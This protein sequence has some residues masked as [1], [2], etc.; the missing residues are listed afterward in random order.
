MA[1]QQKVQLGNNNDNVMLNATNN[2][3]IS[4][5]QHNDTVLFFKSSTAFLSSSQLNAIVNV[6][7]HYYRPLVTVSS[8]KNFT[9]SGE[10]NLQKQ[11]VQH[12][13]LKHGLSVNDRDAINHTQTNNDRHLD[14]ASLLHS[15][16]IITLP[17]G[18]WTLKKLRGLA[19]LL[20]LESLSGIYLRSSTEYLIETETLGRNDVLLHGLAEL[21]FS[22]KNDF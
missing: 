12:Y 20:Q 8:N 14:D 15:M 19:A 3:N 17:T 7:K 5:D 21:G 4:R 10:F 13:L 6:I 16:I 18:E 11:D 22:I 1:G 2:S 9:V